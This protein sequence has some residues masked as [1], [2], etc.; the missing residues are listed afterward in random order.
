MF[1]GKSPDV[2]GPIETIIPAGA[3]A[4]DVI[5]VIRITGTK[6]PDTEYDKADVMVKSSTK[7][8]RRTAAGDQEMP[9]DSLHAGQVV[10]TKFAGPVLQSLPVRATAQWI[11]VIA[12]KK[13]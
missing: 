6:E 3:G 5:G 10:E 8:A 9:F 11:V 2:R 13:R 1:D 7:I 4:T 12:E